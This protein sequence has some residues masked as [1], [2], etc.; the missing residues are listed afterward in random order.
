[1]NRKS[2][3]CAFDTFE[4]ITSDEPSPRTFDATDLSSVAALKKITPHDH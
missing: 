1:V 3:L 4:I 2:T